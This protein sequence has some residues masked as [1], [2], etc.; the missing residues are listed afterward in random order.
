M[1]IQNLTEPASW[2]Y[3]SS[4]AN[5]ANGI[6]QGL[7]LGNLVNPHR[8]HQGLDFLHLS[9]DHWPTMP[10]A[11]PEYDD[12]ELRKSARV[13]N[14]TVLPGPQLPAVE[15][16]SSWKELIEA[17]A[18]SLHRAA[19]SQATNQPCEAADY[20]AADTA[21]LAKAQLD[22]FPDEVKALKSNRPFPSGSHLCSLSPDYDEIHPVVLDPHHPLTKLLIQD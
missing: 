3:V 13:G 5:P 22:S 21:L 6:T 1:E 16:F 12:S 4:A 14:V 15:D 11:D 18:R 7:T 8:W 20:F 17:T 10:S 9:E 2:I 19:D